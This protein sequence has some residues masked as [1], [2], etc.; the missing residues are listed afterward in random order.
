MSCRIVLMIRRGVFEVFTRNPDIQ[1][2]PP[3]VDPGGHH[4]VVLNISI[5]KKLFSLSQ[6]VLLTHPFLMLYALF[7]DNLVT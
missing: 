1:E 5:N 2:R 7:K 6:V 4:F 3:S